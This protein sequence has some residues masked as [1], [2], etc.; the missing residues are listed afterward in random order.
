MRC[1]CRSFTAVYSDEATHPH[2]ARARAHLPSSSLLLILCTL[3]FCFFFFSG[4]QKQEKRENNNTQ[5]LCCCFSKPTHTIRAECFW[6]SRRG[7]A[8]IHHLIRYR[9][10]EKKRSE[11]ES[12]REHIAIACL[13]YIPKHDIYKKRFFRVAPTPYIAECFSNSRRRAKIVYSILCCFSFPLPSACLGSRCLAFP[14]RSR[15]AR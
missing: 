15:M 6:K 14:R 10:E 7:Q 5:A 4:P 3:F 11:W 12:E 8:K 2:T 1:C 13:G 9:G